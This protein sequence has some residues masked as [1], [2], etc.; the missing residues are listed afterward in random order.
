[1]I[2][3]VRST[4]RNVKCWHES[5]M[6]RRCTAAGMLVVE[7]QLRKILGYRDMAKLV[8]ATERHAML[9]AQKNA[10]RQE[11]TQALPSDRRHR[12]SLMSFTTIPQP[13]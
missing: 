4:Q 12:G 8:N 9:L 13:L 7:Q 3:I 2:E 6:R 11:A 10:A 1:M 5:D